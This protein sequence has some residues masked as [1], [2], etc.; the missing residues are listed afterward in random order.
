MAGKRARQR[1]A[2]VPKA[3]STR[4]GAIDRLIES[5]WFPLVGVSAV[6]VGIPLGICIAFKLLGG[7]VW[8]SER[9]AVARSLLGF[10][11][12]ILLL[13]GFIG[14]LIDA[15]SRKPEPGSSESLSGST[16][17][18]PPP[19]DPWR[20]EMREKAKIRLMGLDGPNGPGT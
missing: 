14:W 1:E 7:L 17:S 5:K 13:G 15:S 20:E 10:L 3:G 4:S 11:L 19:G 9:S 8:L 18:F 16:G 12:G 6:V 2:D